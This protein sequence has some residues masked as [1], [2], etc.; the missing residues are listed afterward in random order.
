MKHSSRVG[1]RFGELSSEAEGQM[2]QMLA[3][4]Q[5]GK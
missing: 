4:Q 5:G 2:Q 1:L 3:G